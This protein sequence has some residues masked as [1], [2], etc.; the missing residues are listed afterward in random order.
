MS[1]EYGLPIPTLRDLWQGFSS[2]GKTILQA[3]EDIFGDE[4]CKV[5]PEVGHLPNDARG[6]ENMVLA[7]HQEDR[8]EIRRQPAVHQR[9]LEFILKVGD[10]PQSSEDR[11]AV[12]RMGEIDQQPLKGLDPN[13]GL[14]RETFLEHFDP[15][16]HGEE[17]RLGGVSQN[18]DH[19]F[20][21]E[22]K[23]ALHQV[24]M[25]QGGGIE[26]SGIDGA[27]NRHRPPSIKEWRRRRSET[28]RALQ[29]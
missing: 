29:R 19:Q 18:R 9:H 16:F 11:I 12:H 24:D 8:F 14:I 21:H 20:I 23:A 15:I 1:H 5:P 4:A 13:P 28:P 3:G 26:G 10:G 25:P 22:E 6:D 2:I 27:L 7:R 17:R